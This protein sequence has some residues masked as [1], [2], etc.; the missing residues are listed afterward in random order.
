M[1]Q[2]SPKKPDMLPGSLLKMAYG[3]NLDS[4][5]SSVPGFLTKVS[6]LHH[7]EKDSFVLY[8]GL[9]LIAGE[10]DTVRLFVTQS[11]KLVSL[12]DSQMGKWGHCFE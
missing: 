3:L 6:R 7:V 9:A 1:K 10:V 5:S 8:V 4:V 11:G 2:V 12:P